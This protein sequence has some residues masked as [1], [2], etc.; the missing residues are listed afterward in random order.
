MS[1]KAEDKKE[2]L[3]SSL[4]EVRGKILQAVKN[5]PPEKHDAAFLGTWSIKDL[6]AHLVGWD[7]ANLLAVIEI[8]SGQVPS[9]YQFYDRDWSGFNAHL[10]GTYKR[11]DLT[12][13]I[14]SAKDSHRVLLEC[15]KNLPAVEF[16]KDRGLR[17]K[18]YKIIISRLLQV[19][20]E[21]E[22]EHL[23]QINE[24]I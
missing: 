10:I 1:A 12:K 9:F 15:L 11:D 17:F 24:F 5:S 4:I 6:L 13:L 8:S 19:E 23:N 2:E 20:I 7:Y 3:I 22:K 21:D 14:R 16:P 18:G